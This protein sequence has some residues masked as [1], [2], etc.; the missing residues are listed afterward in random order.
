MSGPFDL[1]I[2]NIKTNLNSLIEKYT[3]ISKRFEKTIIQQNEKLNN[4]I[5][6]TD[7]NYN[8]N[9]E[10]YKFMKT[11]QPI[12]LN[13][14]NE[15]KT[16]PSSRR[17]LLTTFNPAQVNQG[18]LYPCHSI[19]I[20][21][22]VEDDKLNCAM[23]QRSADLFLGL[24]FNIASTSLLLYIICNYLNNKSNNY[25]YYPDR[26]IITLG[27]T[28]I[29]QSHINAVLTQLQNKPKIFPKL[30]IKIN[31]HENITD[32]TFS[33]MLLENYNHCGVITAKM[34]A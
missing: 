16:N 28:H 23:Y 4:N 33:D 25:I 18:V 21:F 14:I 1:E 32:Y 15:I 34:I 10:S 13:N 6:L 19:I 29:Y 2:Y 26:V 3:N 11:Y 9:L 5:P 30:T 27:D 22:Y 7:N 17:I 8:E 31:N 12:I 24:P 20:Q